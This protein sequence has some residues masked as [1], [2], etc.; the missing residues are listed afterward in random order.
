VAL[1]DKA[2]G[3][4]SPDP[5]ATDDDDV[6]RTMQHGPASPHNSPTGA[7]APWSPPVPMCRCRCAGADVPVPVPV[8]MCRG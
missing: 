8:R 7:G 4:A 1:F 2:Y 6:H 3:Q 5:A